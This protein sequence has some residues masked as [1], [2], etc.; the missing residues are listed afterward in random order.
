MH[1]FDKP[2]KDV[3]VEDIKCLIDEQV[4]ESRVLDYK[5]ALYG[6]S[7]RDKKDFLIDVSAFANTAGGY[8]VIGVDEEDG[9]PKAIEGVELEG[10]ENIKLRFENLLR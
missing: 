6:N 10:L 1:P 5:K 7:D 9:V 3:V 2:L 8:L 4:A